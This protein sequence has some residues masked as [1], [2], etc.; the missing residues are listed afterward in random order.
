MTVSVGEAACLWL[1]YWRRGLTAPKLM[2]SVAPSPMIWQPTTS[3]PC[4]SVTSLSMPSVQ[5]AKIPKRVDPDED[6]DE[7]ALLLELLS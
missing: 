6:E 5:P 1:G 7:I 3:S 2:R 4:G